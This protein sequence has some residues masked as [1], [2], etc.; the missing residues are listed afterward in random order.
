MNILSID[1]D[2]FQYPTRQELG[3]Y[4]DGIDLSTELSQIV[5]AVHRSK[6][7]NVRFDYRNF[8]KLLNIIKKQSSCIPVRI[9]NSH[10]HAYDFIGSVKQDEPITVFNID[11]HHDLFNDNKTLD[12]GNW[13][14]FAQKDFNVMIKWITKKASLEAYGI[15]QDIINLCDIRFGL[16]K[17]ANIKFDAIFI[18]RSDAWTP[19]QFDKHFDKLFNV[20]CNKFIKITGE[21]CITKPRTIT[22]IPAL[23]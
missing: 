7:K 3:N 12:C 6:T 18:C 14:S 16:D 5:W 4:P 20:C 19:P 8:A 17:I 13:L 1:F 23:N 15:T 11:Y 9:V 21:K 10:K 22:E 2:F